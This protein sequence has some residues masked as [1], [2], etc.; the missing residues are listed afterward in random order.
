MFVGPLTIEYPIF[1]C[2]N[3]NV[4]FITVH[5][6]I[7]YRRVLRR[8]NELDLA[9]LGC[10]RFNGELYRFDDNELNRTLIDIFTTKFPYSRYPILAPDKYDQFVPQDGYFNLLT[11]NENLTIPTKCHQLSNSGELVQAD[12]G[13][14]VIYYI[15]KIG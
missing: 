11:S 7:C 6:G 9:S 3:A 1:R 2:F 4:R 15:C 12:C 10:H 5:R 14:K 8:A 13:T